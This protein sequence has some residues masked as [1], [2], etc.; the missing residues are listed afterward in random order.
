MQKT[1]STSIVLAEFGKFPFEHF[2][3]G[4]ML[5]YYNRVH[6][7]QRPHLGKG[8]GSLACYVCCGKEM[9]GRICEKMAI[10]ELARGSGK[11]SAFGSTTAGNGASTWG[12]RL[13]RKLSTLVQRAQHMG[14]SSGGW[15]PTPFRFPPHNVECKKGVKAN[16]QLAF[17]EK[18][19]TNREIRTNVQTRYLCFKGMSYE[20]ENYLCDISCVQLWKTLA[21]FRCGNT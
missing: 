5:L 9:L 1:I 18:F 19:F 21:R 10:P 7:H 16:M 8:M 12:K 13:G 15:G 17:I 4:Q 2:A 11:F 14:G 6:G 3:W 20:S